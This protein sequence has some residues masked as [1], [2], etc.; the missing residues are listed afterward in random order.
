MKKNMF[1]MLAA[2]MSPTAFAMR[3]PSLAIK[4]LDQV[5]YNFISN[6][7]NAIESLSNGDRLKRDFAIVQDIRFPPI[8]AKKTESGGVNI[9]F[10]EGTMLLTC[11]YFSDGS[12]KGRME[13]AQIYMEAVRRANPSVSLVE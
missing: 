9:V 2:L 3:S 6:G 10:G 4:K 8:F 11:S 12:R 5:H 1:C 7:L 13:M